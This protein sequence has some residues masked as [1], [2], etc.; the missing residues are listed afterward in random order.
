VTTGWAVEVPAG[1]RVGRWTV[2]EPIATGSWGSVYAA[3]GHDGDGPAEVAL[4]F[5][6]TGTLTP[7][8]VAYLADVADRERRGHERL[9]HPHLIRALEALTVDDPGHPRLD[10]AL[11]IV[12]ERAEASLRDL[13][14]R[15]VGGPVP[16]AGRL[17]E[18]ICEALAYLHGRG[19]VHGDL[20]PAN[21]LL[22]AD[23]SARLADFGLAGELDGTHAYLPP[24]ASP[25]Y[26]P[27]ERWTESLGA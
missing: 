20:K 8:Q 15:A 13:L 27:P 5:L 19:W 16:G 7:R 14:E 24:M 18:E 12:M 10:G 17:V 1:Y 26:V 11:V 3:T 21:V 2:T 9:S 25:D 22:M 23:G 6:P 4:K